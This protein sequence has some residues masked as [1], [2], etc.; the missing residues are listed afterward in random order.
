MFLASS[1]CSTVTDKG[2]P[3]TPLLNQ[4]HS[5]PDNNHRIYV[6]SLTDRDT[7]LL[8]L[9]FATFVF[10]FNPH[11]VILIFAN[12]DLLSLSS[13][14]I[15]IHASN[16]LGFLGLWLGQ[17][18]VEKPHLQGRGCGKDRL[19]R[20]GEATNSR[21]GEKKKKDRFHHG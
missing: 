11:G 9:L 16:L 2:L 7:S 17:H 15:G 8:A 21:H 3:N 1:S 6:L 13:K 5:T 4:N 18:T 10:L 20:G 14:D 19:L 12:G